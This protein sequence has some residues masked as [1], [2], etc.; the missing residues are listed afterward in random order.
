MIYNI[1]QR[2]TVK[3][4]INYGAGCFSITTTCTK[5]FEKCWL[6]CKTKDTIMKAYI[7]N[8]L[9]GVP[10]EE[11]DSTQQGR[12]SMKGVIGKIITL[13]NQTGTEM[14]KPQLLTYLGECFLIPLFIFSKFISWA[15]IDS[16]HVKATINYQGISGNGTFI[17]D[18]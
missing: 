1:T 3:K 13:F 7:Q 6:S 4:Q 8:S 11:H 10:F 15:S 18:D 16:N 12:G 14:D 17:F 5:N 9:Y 2:N